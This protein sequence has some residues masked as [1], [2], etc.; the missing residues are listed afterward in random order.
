M[1]ARRPP[2]PQPSV[3]LSGFRLVSYEI[4]RLAYATKY[5]AQIVDGTR[6]KLPRSH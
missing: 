4:L 1:R 5:A 6:T 3:H 2:N